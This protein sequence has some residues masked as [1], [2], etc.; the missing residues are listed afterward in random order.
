[1]IYKTEINNN[2]FRIVRC[3]IYAGEILNTGI[4]LLKK[5]S[6][7]QLALKQRFVSSTK[8][9]SFPFW[10]VV[11]S[12]FILIRKSIGSKKYPCGTPKGMFALANKTTT[13]W[14]HCDQSLREDISHLCGR[15][16]MPYSSNCCNNIWWCTELKALERSRIIKYMLTPLQAFNNSIY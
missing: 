3:E 9:I 7:W 13:I 8:W 15:P 6:W 11:F 10:I 4:Q 14:T 12:P 1:M 16:M 2:W 5:S